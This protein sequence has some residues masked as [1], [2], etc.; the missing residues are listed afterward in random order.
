MSSLE[1]NLLS[2]AKIE[3][4]KKTSDPQ[5]KNQSLLNF[6][7]IV[8]IMA[9]VCAV[10]FFLLSNQSLRLDEAQSLWQSSR[11][12]PSVLNILARDVHV[13]FYAILLHAWQFLFSNEVATVRL[14]SLFFFVASLPFIYAVGKNAINKS[15]GLFAAVLVAVSP[16]L[17][18]YG[19]EIRMYS[20]L[21]FLTVLNQYFFVKIFQ[22]KNASASSAIW[23]GYIISSFLGIY[24]HYFFWL[25][26][27]TQGVFYLLYRNHFS[28]NTFKKLTYTAIVLAVSILPWLWYVWHIGLINN[29]APLLAKP[30]TIHNY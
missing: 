30:T 2:F 20:L 17:N 27:M 8:L 13:P 6:L 4:E 24:T 5:A 3:P 29:S 23:Y 18:W 9:F 11:S 10:S 25:N 28:K 14:F 7:V 22:S 26:L 19:N 21:T 16:F 1:K 15:V 12:L